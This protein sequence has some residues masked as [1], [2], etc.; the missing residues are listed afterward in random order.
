MAGCLQEN[1]PETEAKTQLD[2]LRLLQ[3]MGVEVSCTCWC[4][5]CNPEPAVPYYCC[6]SLSGAA[7]QSQNQLSVNPKEGTAGVLPLVNLTLRLPIMLLTCPTQQQFFN[8]HQELPLLIVAGS[9][10]LF[11]SF[12]WEAGAAHP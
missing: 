6:K 11:P 9:L 5:S 2:N 10:L 7:Q 4:G 8:L 12:Y 3:G 1:F